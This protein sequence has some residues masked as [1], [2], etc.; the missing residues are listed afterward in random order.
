VIELKEMDENCRIRVANRVLCDW[1][2]MID[3]TVSSC[4][5]YTAAQFERH[6]VDL[7]LKQIRAGKKPKAEY[8]PEIQRSTID[9]GTHALSSRRRRRKFR[10]LSNT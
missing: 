7:A 5:G 4:E 9:A 3:E 1:P 10:E 6:C 2:E 8:D